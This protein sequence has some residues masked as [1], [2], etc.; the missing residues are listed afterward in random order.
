MNA[1]RS[2]P[3]RGFTLIETV[4][5]TVIGGM[6]L[7]GCVAVFLASNRTEQAFS[8]RFQRTSEMW[9][10]QLAVRRTFLNLLMDD[11]TTGTTSTATATTSTTTTTTTTDTDTEAVR[12]RVIL[13]P[14]LGAPAA[15]NGSRPQRLEVTVGRSPVPS[16]VSSQ[17]GRW[18]VEADRANSLDFTSTN[19]SSG[20]IRGVFELRPSGTREVIM[21]NLSLL[22]PDPAL[23]RRMQSDPPPG[24]TLW[25]RPILSAELTEL[26][27]GATPRGDLD[28][29]PDEIRVRLAG[30]YP[31]LKGIDT[32]A[33]Q[34]FKGDERVVAYA[35]STITDLPAYTELEFL[36]LDGQ[37]ASWMFEIGWTTGEEPGSDSDSTTDDTSNGTGGPGVRPPGNGNQ[38]PG[39]G[40][41]NRPPG[42]GGNFD[43]GGNN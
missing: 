9:T 18:L 27:A 15:A 26:E 19:L 10:T 21:M 17:F 16:I 43:M 32:L 25:W 28:G 3:A 29:T 31:V 13:E 1:A 14:D 11:S 35:A 2:H 4:L 33:W 37:Y 7:L 36:L 23:Q 12:P 40:G 38:P 41:G 8:Q 20:A 5:A 22:D 24:W 6:V 30:A 39:S 34:V 42:S